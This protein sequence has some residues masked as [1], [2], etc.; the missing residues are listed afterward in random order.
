MHLLF[1]HLNVLLFSLSLLALLGQRAW[2]RFSWYRR[3]VA[4][5]QRPRLHDDHDE[6]FLCDGARW[7][8]PQAPRERGDRRRPLLA[9][10]N[11][12]EGKNGNGNYFGNRL[13]GPR[14]AAHNYRSIKKKKRKEKKK[15]EGESRK[16]TTNRFLRVI[17][18]NFVQVLSRAASLLFLRA[19]R[20]RSA[21]FP[22]TWLWKGPSGRAPW[23][24]CPRSFW[25]RASRTLRPW[26]TERTRSCG[27]R[28]KRSHAR[29]ATW[30]LSP[31]KTYA[32]QWPDPKI[33]NSIFRMKLIILNS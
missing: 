14:Y 2:G 20:L 27:K 1:I 12:R 30:T 28:G 9:R 19:L 26:T 7:G 5:F 17:Q 8:A 10:E 11:G 4:R 32:Q 13:Q 33:W 16:W 15:K 6:G 22:S 31:W 23:S 18:C 24:R 21:V 29:K 25:T 3:H